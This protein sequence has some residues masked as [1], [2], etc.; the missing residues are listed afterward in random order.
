MNL[1]P[2][3]Q[4]PYLAQATHVVCAFL[5]FILVFAVALSLDRLTVLLI[6]LGWI[7]KNGMYYWVFKAAEVTIMLVDVAALLVIVVLTTYKFLRGL[8]R[9]KV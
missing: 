5:L 1:E 2:Q 9:W 4:N 6:T 8:A 7:E 3:N